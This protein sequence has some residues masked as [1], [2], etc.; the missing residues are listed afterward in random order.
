MKKLIIL[1]TLISVAVLN[2]ARA[3]SAN[4][5]TATLHFITHASISNLHEIASGKLASQK[6]ARADVK[7]YGQRM[8]TDHTKAQTQLMQLAKAKG[9]QVPSQATT[10][11]VNDPMLS[12]ASGKDFDRMYVH[13]MAPSHRQAVILFQDYAIK[14]KDSAVKAFVQQTLPILKQHLAAIMALDAQIKD[15]AK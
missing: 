13:M 9:Y 15:V 11:P 3:Q 1:I 4:T 8:V 2:N 5:D 14:G 12:K 7:A 10:P 6:A